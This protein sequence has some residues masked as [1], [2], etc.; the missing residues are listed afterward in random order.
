MPTPTACISCNI[1]FVTI[2]SSSILRVHLYLLLHLWSDPSP[3]VGTFFQ[4]FYMQ[5]GDRFKL[6]WNYFLQNTCFEVTDFEQLRHRHS[7]SPSTSF[8]PKI[9]LFMNNSLS[10]RFKK[11]V[12]YF[13]IY[14]GMQIHI[15]T[16]Q[17][18]RFCLLVRCSINGIPEAIP[19]AVSWCRTGATFPPHPCAF[20]RVNNCNH[21]IPT[22]LVKCT[23]C[24]WH[25]MQDRSNIS[26]M[27]LRIL[28]GK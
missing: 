17:E 7:P 13:K 19:E 8:T 14:F 12:K 21:V 24:S 1:F 23:L 20:L 6:L 15:H 5:I 27:S 16:L 11:Y 18:R 25:V 28:M 9:S 10:Y 3:S 4:Y 26:S 22:M 2:L